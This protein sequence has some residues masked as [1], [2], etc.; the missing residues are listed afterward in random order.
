MARTDLSANNAPVASEDM[1]PCK[2]LKPKERF[3]K[4]AGLFEE[5]PMP[6]NFMIFSGTMSSS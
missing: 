6:L 1:R 5:Q 4:Y 2:P 3:K